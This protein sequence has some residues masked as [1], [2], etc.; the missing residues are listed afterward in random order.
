MP[1]GGR[2][3]RSREARGFRVAEIE[4][5]AGTELKAHSHSQPLLIYVLSGTY[6]EASA[7]GGRA[8]LGPK[9]LRYLPA[10]CVHANRFAGSARCLVVE[11]AAETMARVEIAS[12]ALS[13]P[14]NLEGPY[15]AWLAGRLYAEFQGEGEAGVAMEGILLELLVE[16]ARHAGRGAARVV[17]DWLKNARRHVESNCLRSVSLA[18]IARV[19]GMH[20]VHVSREFRRHFGVTIGEF[21]RNLRVEHARELLA[22]TTQTLTDIA[23][24][25]GFAD[26]S[27]FSA[28][29]RRLT[30]STP[31]VFRQAAVQAR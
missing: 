22:T 6:S 3:V 25:C 7:N 15:A 30:G 9:S 31:A 11:I 10:G 1:I 2:I 16:S 14:G 12:A 13:R 24:D 8:D 19:T 18:E 28:I 21:L 29:F 20:R 5:R 23:L 4:Y 27:H 17:P 26:Q